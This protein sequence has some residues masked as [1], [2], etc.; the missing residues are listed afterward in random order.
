MLHVYIGA[1]AAL[2][3]GLCN[4]VQRNGGLTG[5]FRSVD[6]RDAAAWNSAYAQRHIEGDRACGDGVDVQS[7]G[8]SKSYDAPF[9]ELLLDV[10]ERHVQRFRLLRVYERS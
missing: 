6:F 2:F 1:D 7:L 10:R 3:L 9:A 4:A 5:G 8:M